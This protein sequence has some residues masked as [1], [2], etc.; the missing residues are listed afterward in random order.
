MV[1]SNC[2]TDVILT[3]IQIDDHTLNLTISCSR[4][5]GLKDE[6]DELHTT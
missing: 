6:S 4:E 5:S 2:G 3:L 1:S